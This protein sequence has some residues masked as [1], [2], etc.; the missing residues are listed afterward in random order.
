MKNI[1]QY[2]EEIDDALYM[3]VSAVDTYEHSS[4]CSSETYARQREEMYNRKAKL[5]NKIK[6]AINSK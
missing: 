3:Y 1:E 2:L 6:E 4:T 5:F